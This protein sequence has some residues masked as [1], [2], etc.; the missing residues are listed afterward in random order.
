[1]T[2]EMGSPCTAFTRH[3]HAVW[4]RH[5]SVPQAQLLL[6]PRTS[7]KC[8][9]ETFSYSAGNEKTS[10]EDGKDS[11]LYFI[12]T[13][14]FEPKLP[15]ALAPPKSDPISVE[16]LSTANGKEIATSPQPCR[17]DADAECM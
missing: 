13:G 12:M 14:K 6:N 17:K 1:M 15:V 8:N 5:R 2:Q 11:R 4:Q 7:L 9:F 3:A 10:R 16:A